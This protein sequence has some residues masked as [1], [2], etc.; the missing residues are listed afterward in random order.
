M[1]RNEIKCI[2][3]MPGEEF[4]TLTTIPNELAKLQDAVGGYIETVTFSPGLVIICD[5]EGRLKD[6][7]YNCTICGVDF[8]GVII[9]VGHDGPELTDIGITMEEWGELL[10]E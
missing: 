6:Y 7:P 10:D 2:I 4:G 8:C 9:A 1:K 3:K 5:E